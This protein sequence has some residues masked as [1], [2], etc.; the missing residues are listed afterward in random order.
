MRVNWRSRV[1][2]WCT[3]AGAF[4]KEEYCVKYI[5]PGCNTELYMNKFDLEESHSNCLLLS[6]RGHRISNKWTRSSHNPTALT[7]AAAGLFC[8]HF[9]VVTMGID[10]AATWQIE[11]QKAPK[12]P[13][14]LPHMLFGLLLVRKEKNK[15]LIN[16]SIKFQHFSISYLNSSVN[17]T[18]IGN[19][20]NFACDLFFQINLVPRKCPQDGIL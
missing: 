19:V 9:V 6:H 4:G 1:Q 17:V 14:S 8:G 13:L 20:A 10:L 11:I 18:S 5:W 3:L 2:F 15:S 16:N 12:V 7:F